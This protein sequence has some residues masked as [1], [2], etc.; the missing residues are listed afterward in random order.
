MLVL[1]GLHCSKQLVLVLQNV[2]VDSFVTS[3]H[4]LS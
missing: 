2:I 4:L 1:V 3:L